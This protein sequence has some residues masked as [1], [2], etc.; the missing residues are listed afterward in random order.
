MVTA[1]DEEITRLNFR[2]P[3]LRPLDRKDINEL[4]IKGLIQEHWDMAGY[5]FTPV[6]ASGLLSM[7]STDSIEE[8]RLSTSWTLV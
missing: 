8:F 5:T 6:K 4:G 3:F 7:E 1:R 2:H